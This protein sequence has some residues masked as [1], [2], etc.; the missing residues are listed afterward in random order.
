M[1]VIPMGHLK[2]AIE[3]VLRESANGVVIRMGSSN[4]TYQPGAWPARRS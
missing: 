3:Q 4:G 1:T 2:L